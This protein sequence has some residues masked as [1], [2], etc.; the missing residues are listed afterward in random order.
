GFNRRKSLSQ[1]MRSLC[2]QRKGVMIE[3]ASVFHT[4]A[5]QGEPPNLCQF[6]GSHEIQPHGLPISQDERRTHERSAT[7]RFLTHLLGQ[8]Y[9]PGDAAALA[10]CAVCIRE[11]EDSARK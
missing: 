1:A 5:S 6:S 7:Y 4:E 3:L 11:T 2:E 10:A 8:G 9:F